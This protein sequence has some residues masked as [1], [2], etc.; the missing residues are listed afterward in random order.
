M[1]SASATPAPSGVRHAAP[2]RSWWALAL[3]WIVY[4]LDAN[5]RQMFFMVLPSITKEFGV[6]ARTMGLYATYI[7]M[8]TALIA[9]PAMVWADRGGHGWRRKYRHLPI[10]IAYT[11]FTCLTGVSVMTASIGALVLMQVL[12][13]AFG[14]AGESIEVTSLAEWW[15]KER[16]GFA[17]G[18]HHTGYPWGTLLGGLIVGGILSAFGPENWRVPFLLFPIPVIVAFSIYW[19]FCNKANYQRL[20]SAITSAGETPPLSSEFAEHTAGAP[21]GSL[22]VA[23]ANPNI[24]V[25]AIVSLLAVVAYFGISFWLPQYLAFVAKYNFAEAAAYS[26]LFTI[27]GGLGQIVWGWLSDR[28]GR[29]FCLILV[30]IWLAVGMV[31]MKF[32][33]MGLG[34]L[35]AVQLFAGFA[36]NAPY[37]LVYA[38]AFDS[39]KPGTT[40]IAGSIINVGIYAGGFG[41]YVIGAMI[42]AKGG[43]SVAEGYYDALY[44]ISGLM[45]AAL[46]LTVFFTRETAGWFKKHDFAIVSKKSCNVE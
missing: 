30:F 9:V 23:L 38:I 20:N 1:R 36:L 26:V 3:L 40:G 33:Y 43:F 13:H 37:T 24:L 41:P 7:T 11:L 21:K 35:I 39:T 2:S 32:T 6:D 12:S 19:F 16:R 46:I 18:A 29:K 8:A 17:L 14:G 10:V 42:G 4:A 27:T 25:I 31:L 44:F 22:L 5:S 45:V 28:I 34:T 15:S